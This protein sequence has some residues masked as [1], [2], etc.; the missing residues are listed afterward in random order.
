MVRVNILS[1]G[2]YPAYRLFDSWTSAREIDTD[3]AFQVRGVCERERL[4][5]AFHVHTC[6]EISAHDVGGDP[7]ARVRQRGGLPFQFHTTKSKRKHT[8]PHPQ[9]HAYMRM[10]VYLTLV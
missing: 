7:T 10:Y 5:I 2:L 9:N 6:M 4:C 3:A 1:A 8:Q